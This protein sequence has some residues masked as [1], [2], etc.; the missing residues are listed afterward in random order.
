TLPWSVTTPCTV[1]T[2]RSDVL[3]PSAVIKAIFVFIVSH[4]S[5]ASAAWAHAAAA[6]TKS[7]AATNTRTAFM[8][9]R[10]IVL[11]PAVVELAPTERAPRGVCVALG[12]RSPVPRRGRARGAPEKKTA[13]L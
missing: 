12:P 5:G 9:E 7:G 4:A 11:P 8:T 3:T 1:S 10:F 6:A 13:G 2:F